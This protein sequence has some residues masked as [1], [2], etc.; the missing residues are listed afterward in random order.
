MMSKNRKDDYINIVKL[1]KKKLNMFDKIFLEGIDLFDLF[2]DDIDLFI[3]FLG[4]KV[5]YLFYINVMIGGS[6][7]VYK[8]NEFLLKI[9]DY[10]NL[11]MVIGS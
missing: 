10:F 1:F 8:I 5:L 4:M 7:K 11:L 9:V 3:E 2:M 6:E